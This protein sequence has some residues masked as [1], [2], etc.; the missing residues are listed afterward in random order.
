MRPIFSS[1]GQPPVQAATATAPRPPAP[2]ASVAPSQMTVAPGRPVFGRAAAAAPETS[3]APVGHAPAPSASGEPATPPL[4]EV[5]T[6][7]ESAAVEFPTKAASSRPKFGSGRQHFVDDSPPADAFGLDDDE[8]PPV[9]TGRPVFGTRPAG[10]SGEVQPSEGP[11]TEEI[12]GRLDEL[13]TINDWAVGTIWNEERKQVKI[14]GTG[15][16]D[17]APGLE[18]AFVGYVKTHPQ[19][20]DSFEVVA[21]TPHISP[22]PMAIMHFIAANYK[23]IGLAKAD[24][25]VKAIRSGQGEQ[26][27]EDLR[28]RLINDPQSVDLTELSAGAEYQPKGASADDGSGQGMGR[29]SVVYR[30]LA[31]RLAGVPGMKANVLKALAGWLVKENGPY[32]GSVIPADLAPKCWGML[33]RD[34]YTPMAHVDGYAWLSAEAIGRVAGVPRELPRRLSALAQ[35]ALQTGSEAGGHA[36]MESDELKGHV[37]KLDGQVDPGEAIDNALIHGLVEKDES[38]RIYHPKILRAEKR[39]AAGLAELLETGRP[40]VNKGKAEVDG[41]I[42]EIARALGFTKGLDKS[43]VDAVSSIVRSPVRVHTLIGGPGCG[44]T[45]VMEVLAKMLPGKDIVFATP[46]GKAAKVLHARV[47]KHGLSSSTLHSALGFCEERVIHGP[48]DP[49]RADVL[50]IDEASM[51]DIELM[52]AAIA[53]LESGAHVVFVGDHEQLPSIGPGRVL[54]D[55]LEMDGVDHNR[56]NTTHRNS[57]GILELVNSCRDG[58]LDLGDKDGVSFSRGLGEAS[59]QIGMVA[60]A[61]T[62]AVQRLG[63]ENVIL[64][65][66]RRKG[67]AQTPGWN[68]T[69]TNAILRDICNPHALKVGGTGLHIGDRVIIRKNMVVEQRGTDGEP[70]S[71]RAESVVNGDVGTIRSVTDPTK[72]GGLRSLL[73]QWVDIRLDDGRLI[74]LPGHCISSLEHAYALTVHAAQGSEYKEVL[75]VATPGHSSFVNRSML[76][77][78]LSRSREHL[79]VF[80][81]DADLLKIAATPVPRRNTALVERVDTMRDTQPEDPKPPRMRA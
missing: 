38:G 21:A 41:R 79:H 72:K 46:T 9:R 33:A 11:Q 47:A 7:V 81:N 76:L 65:M 37:Y 27:L 30:D 13:R 62:D 18:Y 20:G 66:S 55:L 53:A 6:S 56:L 80:A 19:H 8:A 67:D 17:L 25:F 68:T 4:R 50:V 70:D 35:Y 16:A 31:T 10:L 74:N 32:E 45:T 54:K 58:N 48:D 78:G 22:N 23:G 52:D 49:L 15:L 43:Q 71:S 3:R 36:F 63:F 34:P 29:L 5:P 51:P 42:A 64:L 39:L 73:P 44:K 61:Y 1:R 12:I 75:L 59:E 2:A 77:T 28:H 24:K 40:L 26:G 69:F 60:T 57:G 14:T